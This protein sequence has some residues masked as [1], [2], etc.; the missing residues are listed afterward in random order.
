MAVDEDKIQ[1]F[2][3]YFLLLLLYGGYI[4]IFTKVLTLYQS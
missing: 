4:V 2:T 1:D 3:F